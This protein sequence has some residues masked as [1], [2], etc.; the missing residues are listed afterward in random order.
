MATSDEVF[1]IRDGQ[2]NALSYRPMKAG[3]FGKSLEDALQNLLQNYPQLIPGKQ[4]EPGN[5]DP[6]RFVLLRR[7]A[8]IGGW[9][10]DHLYVDQNGVLTLVETKLIQNPESR[11]EVIGQIIEYAANAQKMWANGRARQL[12]T[13]YWNSRQRDVDELLREAFGDDLDVDTLWGLVEENL[14]RGEVRLLVAA[15]ELRPEVRRM[16]EYLN[17]EM[18]NATVLGLELQCYGTDTTSLVLVP[19]VVGQSE[20]ARQEKQQV[21]AGKTNQTQFLESCPEEVQSFFIDVL[22]SAQHRKLIVYWG[23]KGF[24]LRVPRPV[25]NPLTV[26]YGYPPRANGRSSAH[27]QGYIA[28]SVDAEIAQTIGAKY[29]AIPHVFKGGDYT[30]WLDLTADTL[31]SARQMLE[32]AWYAAERIRESAGIAN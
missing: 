32:V 28:A 9:S 2:L 24:S 3:L 8:P 16:I 17:H 29:L 6:P 7:E 20:L 22:S 26:F 18:Q 23:L 13:E 31:G 12:A 30:Y 15:D 5:P 21:S 11:R 4:I 1:M 19:R 14:R 25:G 27:I 10:L